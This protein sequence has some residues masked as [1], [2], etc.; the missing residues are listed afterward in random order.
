MNIRLVA[1]AGLI[2]AAPAALAQLQIERQDVAR[3]APLETKPVATTNRLIVKFK[4][5]AS[6]NVTR[7]GEINPVG[8]HDMTQFQNVTQNHQLSVKKFWN[9]DRSKLDALRQKAELASGEPQPDLTR[10]VYIDIGNPAM[11]AQAKRDLA[12]L[13]EVEWVD[14]DYEIKMHSTKP[15]AREFGPALPGMV[16]GG[17][18]DL[19]ANQTWYSIDN[20]GYDVQGLHD[21]GQFILD[22]NLQRP[23]WPGGNGTRGANVRVGVID[24]AAWNMHEDLQ[25]INM[26]P[27]VPMLPPGIDP[28]I[29]GGYNHGAACL[30]IIGAR[31]N[32]FGMTGIVPEAELWFFP[33]ISF[34]GARLPEA[35]VGAYTILE[36]GDIL[37]VSLG[38]GDRPLVYAALEATLMTIGESLG[39]TTFISAGNDANDL[40]DFALPAVVDDAGTLPCVVVGA[41]FPEFRADTPTGGGTSTFVPFSRLGFT[42]H[43]FNLDPAVDSLEALVHVQS[44]GIEVASLGY[45]DLFIPAGSDFD[46]FNRSYTAA[47][48][49]TSAACPLTAGVAASVQGLAKMFFGAPLLPSQIRSLVAGQS[50]RQELTISDIWVSHS[51][52]P[53]DM[54]PGDGMAI[55]VNDNVQIDPMTMQP[56]EE[57]EVIGGHTRVD[58]LL[59]AFFTSDWFAAETELTDFRVISGSYISGGVVL[60]GN[61]DG[62]GIIV[63]SRYVSPRSQP[64]VPPF[65]EARYVVYGQ[66]TD[67]GFEI[68]PTTSNPIIFTFGIQY[69]S[70]IANGAPFGGLR[71]VEVY[72][73]ATQ[74]W[75]F[76]AVEQIGSGVVTVGTV[77]VNAA[78]T[79]LSPDRKI[80]FRQWILGYTFSVNNQLFE[81]L[82]DQFLFASTSGGAGGGADDPG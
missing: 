52:D 67:V 16:G 22:N 18:P 79:Y 58:Q 81:A 2:A 69:A 11:I 31:D 54:P 14:W 19:T 28:E 55:T 8:N 43:H 34:T 1:L 29:F 61:I 13:P 32:D 24:F 64:T 50:F 27:G 36:R 53:T 66:V 68:T 33:S 70:G 60:C 40:T 17:T 41:G 48:G 75:D 72:N 38:L 3:H 80:F 5:D 10:I 56:F 47:F 44:W 71:G 65:P 51:P 59:S 76:L 4:D 63:G 82:Y 73:W 46:I 9:I 74:R 21:R 25:P 37:S 78:A 45:G 35:F 26:E 12:Q 20:L 49:G 39:V 57:S 7:N 23:E 6:L 77:D 42:N 15:L 62:S 30:G